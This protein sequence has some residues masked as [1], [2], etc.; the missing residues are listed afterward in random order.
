[1]EKLQKDES[2]DDDGNFSFTPK[3]MIDKLGGYERSNIENFENVTHRAKIHVIKDEGGGSNT[4]SEHNDQ[5]L[6]NIDDKLGIIN[7]KIEQFGGATEHELNEEIY[8]ELGIQVGGGTGDETTEGTEGT[9]GDENKK[10]TEGENQTGGYVNA[11]VQDDYD[12]LKKNYQEEYVEGSNGSYELEDLDDL[13]GF[14]IVDFLGESTNV[15]IKQ[16]KNKLKVDDD[17]MFE[18]LIYNFSLDPELMYNNDIPEHKRTF[19]YVKITSTNGKV[20]LP[21]FLYRTFERK[22]GGD[23]KPIYDYVNELMFMKNYLKNPQN[24]L[25]KIVENITAVKGYHRNLNT[26]YVTPVIINRKTEYKKGAED[27]DNTSNHLIWYHD[28]K[29]Y[30]DSLSKYNPRE[31]GGTGKIKHSNAVNGIHSLLRNRFDISNDNYLTD[32]NINNTEKL[33][34]DADGVLNEKPIYKQHASD[35]SVIN[36]SILNNFRTNTNNTHVFY[37]DNLNEFGSTILNDTKYKFELKKRK[38]SGP[39]HEYFYNNED[40]TIINRKIYN[41]ENFNIVGYFVHSFD[42]NKRD[43]ID[44]F[45]KCCVWYSSDSGGDKFG[46]DYDDNETL[47]KFD[48]DD[49]DDN[50]NKLIKLMN[51]KNNNMYIY[52]SLSVLDPEKSLFIFK[53]IFAKIFTL[54]NILNNHKNLLKYSIND[55]H[56]VKDFLSCYDID[57]HEIDKSHINFFRNLFTSK[58]LDSMN[59]IIEERKLYEKRSVTNNI[60]EKN[61]KINILD[62]YPIKYPFYGL[63]VDN[64]F[65]R[66]LFLRQNIDNGYL[67]IEGVDRSISHLND[68]L[69]KA[70]H[71][72]NKLSDIY[73]ELFQ[74]DKCNKEETLRKDNKLVSVDPKKVESSYS[75]YH[76][77]EFY[78]NMDNYSELTSICNFSSKKKIKDILN[79]HYNELCLNISN[80]HIKYKMDYYKKFITDI[81][82]QI[83]NYKN[84]NVNDTNK[85]IHELIEYKNTKTSKQLQKLDNIINYADND[86][87]IDIRNIKRDNDDDG[88]EIEEW[89][90]GAMDVEMDSYSKQMVDGKAVVAEMNNKVLDPSFYSQAYQDMVDK[91]EFNLYRKL[92]NDPKYSCELISRKFRYTEYNNICN[93]IRSYIIKLNINIDIS[94]LEELV[95][96]IHKEFENLPSFESFKKAK[97]GKSDVSNEEIRARYNMTYGENLKTKQYGIYKSSIVIAKL[98]VELETR[99]PPYRFN[100]L[101][102]IRE[103]D[104]KLFD[105]DTDIVSFTDDKID[106]LVQVGA[107]K[108]QLGDSGVIMIQ[109]QT[110][111]LDSITQIS[112]TLYDKYLENPHVEQL[113]TLREQYKNK[114]KLLISETKD[115]NHQNY[116]FNDVFVGTNDIRDDKVDAVL[117]VLETKSMHINDKYIENIINNKKY[118]VLTELRNVLQSRFRYLDH[119]KNYSILKIINDNQNYKINGHGYPPDKYESE[120]LPNCIPKG[121]CIYSFFPED[122][123]SYG[124]YDNIY[125]TYDKSFNKNLDEIVRLDIL[126]NLGIGRTAMYLEPQAYK[127][128]VLYDPNTMK[129][130]FAYTENDTK[131]FNEKYCKIDNYENGVGGLFNG[132][133]ALSLRDKLKQFCNGTTL[134]TSDVENLVKTLNNLNMKQLSK[135]EKQDN[136]DSYQ[137][138]FG[139]TDD[140]QETFNTFMNGLESNLDIEP[141]IFGKFKKYM[142]HNLGYYEKLF[143]SRDFKSY[144]VEDSKSLTGDNHTSVATYTSTKYPLESIKNTSVKNSLE[145]TREFDNQVIKSNNDK[146]R[147]N[148][149]KNIFIEY[150]VYINLFKNKFNL[151]S[152]NYKLKKFRDDSTNGDYTFKHFKT[153][154]IGLSL[155][156]PIPTHNSKN[157]FNLKDNDLI[158]DKVDQYDIMKEVVKYSKFFDDFE[159]LYKMDDIDKVYGETTTYVGKRRINESRFSNRVAGDVILIYIVKEFEHLL[160]KCK[161]IQASNIQLNIV[162]NMSKF[163]YEF[164]EQQ[165]SQIKLLDTSSEDIIIMKTV[166][167]HRISKEESLLS[168]EQLEFRHVLHEQGIS[169]DVDAFGSFE[170]TEPIQQED[171]IVD[172]VLYGGDDEDDY[173][174]DENFGNIFDSDE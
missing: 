28:Q 115:T 147:L 164:L 166:M 120:E 57:F 39:I 94:N 84:I 88:K 87:D 102:K 138:L 124:G 1:M 7:D 158:Y 135:R 47:N 126:N 54:D 68:I 78:K 118:S 30:I 101:Y 48:S 143:K 38:L 117:K 128:F 53:K 33:Y 110:K 140:N 15:L 37:L 145:R 77:L 173:I 92:K 45:D 116:G 16:N 13:D 23:H 42:F 99:I 6:H 93:K 8:K 133:D 165:A 113:F 121:T 59:D 44:Q 150:R 152:N 127:G 12:K 169:M 98:C 106:F 136:Y 148:N 66:F 90:Q 46:I 62:K 111:F 154:D 85:K 4:L 40:N 27:D 112:N 24:Y 3:K 96:E 122:V 134:L 130:G 75:D 55:I 10:G 72:Y 174:D 25:E 32:E 159:F 170:N 36:K 34:M 168:K 60:I 137:Q 162:T 91:N 20:S 21:K 82:T 80:F 76:T 129:H 29:K 70:N 49:I 81:E 149:L 157:L 19:G 104:R 95:L 14:E 86:V 123:D 9:E 114:E 61:F 153:L 156:I 109:T 160:D 2:Y 105:K 56:D 97:F 151:I 50:I 64:D 67:N 167:N 22:E 5:I 18:R 155:P 103:S 119:Y 131:L 52:S 83:E 172:D 161:E 139:I 146:Q 26:Y 74:S 171:D 43:N 69:E 51:E 31:L 58:A 11:I 79:C 125:G 108:S 41:G 65:K 73:V 144:L 35:K 141:N 132:L 142:Q 107:H 100:N 163:I 63:R 71:E 17:V 89:E